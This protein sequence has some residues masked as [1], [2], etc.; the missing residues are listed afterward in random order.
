MIRKIIFDTK[1]DII[2]LAE[3]NLSWKLINPH[4]RLPERT[5][6]WFKAVHITQSY[7]FQFPAVTPHLAGGTALLTMDESVH[8]VVDREVDEMGRWAST[9][10][11]GI[12]GRKVRLISAYRCVKN[13]YGPLSTWN[14]QRYLLDLKNC[15]TD[16]ITQFDSDLKQF[17]ERCL[18]AG[19]LIILGIDANTDIRKGQFTA[20]MSALGLTNLY[21]KKFGNDIPPTYA[22]GSL[23][24]DGF[25]VSPALDNVEAGFLPVSC[26][27]RVL[28]VDIPKTI[29]FGTRSEPLPSKV[30]KR[31]IL[32]D[33][34][35]LVRYTTELEKQLQLH[36]VELQLERVQAL[37]ASGMVDEAIALYNEV[38]S[39]RTK[40]I[41]FADRRCR[42]LR[43]GQIPFS[44]T[45]VENWK[46]I[47]AWKLL[48]RKL[49]GNKIDSKY[50]LRTLK[51]AGIKNHHDLSLS[52]AKENLQTVLDNYRYE[53]NQAVNYRATWFEELATARAASGNISAAQEL[54]NLFAR[55]RQRE[56]A[57]QIKNA[58]SDTGIRGLSTIEV[59]NTEGEWVELTS[60]KD[61]EEALLT[62][63]A[64][65][66]NQ[67]AMTPFATE[68]LLSTVGKFGEAPGAQN[69]L[70]GNSR[71][72]DIDE[73]AAELIPFFRQAIETEPLSEISEHD[74]VVSWKKVNE[75]TSAGP[76]GIT[77]PHFKAHTTSPIL[78]KIDTMMANLPYKY[79]FSPD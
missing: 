24:I 30:S 8:R 33:P 55:E 39:I 70:K 76:S 49:S 73:W 13:I 50:L 61:I 74:Y 27:H 56:S 22:R 17:L 75:R 47:L 29:V 59:K 42:K 16:P 43:M 9:S 53:K 51:A 12:K 48:I 67:A 20:M 65:R 15:Q 3:L 19:E 5:R 45:L 11:R 14:Q 26:D 71:I 60:Q 1:A 10:L 52:D 44:P 31:L 2:A 34:R 25:F 62:E 40:A 4:D 69:L 66:F 7:P 63:L 36:Q 64:T 77:I 18:D 23:P 35:V 79:G 28:W 58:L 41:L 68:P 6:G 46:K 78:T 54:R 32:Q 21:Q 37:F 72:W 38:D 57:R